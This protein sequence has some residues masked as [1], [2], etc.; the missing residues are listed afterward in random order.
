MIIIL[1]G[2]DGSGKNT[3]GETL[4]K[5]L[6]LTFFQESSKH[7]FSFK[8][9]KD[10]WEYFVTGINCFSLDLFNS[11]DDFIKDRFHLSEYTYSNFFNRKSH[12][13]FS[14]IEENLSN[15]NKDIFLVY[16]DV[17][18]ETSYKRTLPKNDEGI[19]DS[20]EF[21]I[22]RG[23][24]NE[25]FNKSKLKKIKINSND[26]IENITKEIITFIKKETHE[27]TN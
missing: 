18:Y 4:S 20:N 1:E 24:L 5:E 27:K 10:K 14:T 7:N 6:N 11:F 2:L 22:Q 3:I 25:S 8:K 23:L 19:Y 17:D 21:N 12:L 15:I 26:K 9:E 16:L 13:D